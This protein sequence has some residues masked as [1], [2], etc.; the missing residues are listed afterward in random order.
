MH[1]E[2]GTRPLEQIYGE[3]MR[4]WHACSTDLDEVAH[5]LVLIAKTLPAD[6]LLGKKRKALDQLRTH[7]VGSMR[8]S[9]LQWWSVAYRQY[10]HVSSLRLSVTHKPGA[11]VMPVSSIVK[12]IS[13]LR[14]HHHKRFDAL[15]TAVLSKD[16]QYLADH[17]HEWSLAAQAIVD[18]AHHN[19]LVWVLG[20]QC[21]IGQRAF[22]A[23]TD[24]Y[25]Q[26]I[27]QHGTLMEQSHGIEMFH[28]ACLEHHQMVYDSW[29]RPFQLEQ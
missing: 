10:A 18:A 27:G 24:G 1:S 28:I 20:E 23:F 22:K 15:Y 21:R 2:S 6:S 16:D 3:H 11:C 17:Q 25:A 26:L 4:Y 7:N 8:D 9:L 19:R 29:M 12:H 13:L 5:R 14:Q